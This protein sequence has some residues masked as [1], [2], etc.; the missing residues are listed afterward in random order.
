MDDR[1]YDLLEKLYL[2]VQGIKG[3]M[4][5]K[6]DIKDM[7]VK[8]DLKN[9]ATK[10][11]LKNFATKD[12]LKDFATKDDLK[13]FV[14]KDDIKN[15]ATKDDIELLADELH[16]EIQTVLDEVKDL[17]NDLSTMEILTTKNAFDIAKLNAIR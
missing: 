13:N 1:V 5:T 9:F 2:E 6:N 11:D 4:A 8:D 3:N 15:M 16:T 12:D 14:T 10:D 7:V 17:R